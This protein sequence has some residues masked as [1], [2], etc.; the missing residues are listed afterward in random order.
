M[1]D[2][3]N[4]T[5]PACPPLYIQHG[6]SCYFVANNTGSVVQAEAMCQR[7]G[8]WFNTPRL[9]SPTSYFDIA[10]LP[11]TRQVAFGMLTVGGM[12]AF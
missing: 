5:F 2:A 9:F 10:W 4:L 11:T 7:G 1:Q 3:T 12:G 8:G 6:Q